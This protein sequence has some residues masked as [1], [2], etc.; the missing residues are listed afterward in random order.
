MIDADG[1]FNADGGQRVG[2]RD[3]GTDDEDGLGFGQVFPVVERPA[4]ADGMTDGVNIVQ[5]AVAGAAIELVGSEPGTHELLEQIQL[6]V[7]AA[8]GD[9]AGNGFR[10][11]LAMDVRQP[12]N[13]GL[14]GI[15]PGRL[16]QGV[17]CA[18]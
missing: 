10:S 16:C 8:G 14:H 13:D 11:V 12:V 2:F 17:I 18:D 1:F 15:E 7:R 3:I 5:V 4:N 9:E 6:F